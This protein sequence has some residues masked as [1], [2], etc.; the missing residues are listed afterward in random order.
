MDADNTAVLHDQCTACLSS[1]SRNSAA[2][3]TLVVLR[4]LLD[5]CPLDQLVDDLCP[6]HRETLRRPGE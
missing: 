5:G 3:A 2:A 6:V 4:M 1:A